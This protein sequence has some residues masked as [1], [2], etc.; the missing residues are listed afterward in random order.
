MKHKIHFALWKARDGWRW[1]AIRN[2]KIIAESGESYKRKS[3]TVKTLKAIIA[4]VAAGDFALEV[5]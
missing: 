5:P 3:G 2:G 1:H 4:A